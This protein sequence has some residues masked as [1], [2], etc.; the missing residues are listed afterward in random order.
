[1]LESRTLVDAMTQ[2]KPLVKKPVFA[3]PK[4]VTIPLPSKK[5]RTKKKN[6][7]NFGLRD[8]SLMTPRSLPKQSLLKQSRNLGANQ[9]PRRFLWKASPMLYEKS[10][11]VLQNWTN[12]N[13]TSSHN[14]PTKNNVARYIFNLLFL[15]FFFPG[16]FFSLIFFPNFFCLSNWGTIQREKFLFQIDC[17]SSQN[18]T[19]FLYLWEH[20]ARIHQTKAKDNSPPF[21]W[22]NF[23]QTNST[24]EEKTSSNGN[25]WWRKRISKTSQK[26]QHQTQFSRDRKA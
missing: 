5:K 19:R 7:K 18:N 4:K 17:N 2:Q 6:E 24:E 23:H 11:K 13:Q 10:Q 20:V 16:I 12:C 21:A 26:C 25:V 15:V 9:K 8:Q 1:M 3:K 22:A 14:A